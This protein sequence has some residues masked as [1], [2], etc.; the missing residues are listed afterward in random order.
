MIRGRK[1]EPGWENV[2]R[3]AGELELHPV[4]KWGDTDG[5]CRQRSEAIGAV[6]KDHVPSPSLQLSQ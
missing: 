5:C 2:I 4:G 3:R 1:R 6:L